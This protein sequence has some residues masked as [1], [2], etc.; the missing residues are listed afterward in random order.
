MPRARLRARCS[1]CSVFSAHRTSGGAMT[2]PPLI[3]RA[4]L[5]GDPE[6]RFLRISPDGTRLAYLAPHRGVLSIWVRATDAPGDRSGDR[7]IAHDP[8]RGIQWFEWQGD[9]R[10][11][12]YAQDRA[13]DENYHLLQAGRA[14]GPAR[15]LTPGERVKVQAAAVDPRTPGEILVMT[16]QR[17]PS[18]FDVHRLDLATGTSRLDTPNPGGVDAWLCD[19]RLVV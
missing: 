10:G 18:V 12:L 4:L 6:I 3:P 2:L 19:D 9:S 11:V 17:D 1:E 15:D 8:E 14:G 13:G 16:N 7:V 5:F